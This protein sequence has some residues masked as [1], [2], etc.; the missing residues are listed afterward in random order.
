MY[1]DCSDLRYVG[2]AF[3]GCASRFST[4][5]A[6]SRL[7]RVANKGARRGFG[8]IRA[9]RLRHLS[10]G[11]SSNSAVRVHLGS[12][13]NSGW[14]DDSELSCV[15]GAFR[16][17]HIVTARLSYSHIVKYSLRQIPVAPATEP[18]DFYAASGPG[19]IVPATLLADAKTFA[20]SAFAFDIRVLV[21]EHFI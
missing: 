11:F 3:I 9:H 7:E 1:D 15:S 6:A 4:A 17:S 19:A 12:A 10:V 8:L 14:V 16:D 2:G 20:A 13:G 21:H 5:A 18:H